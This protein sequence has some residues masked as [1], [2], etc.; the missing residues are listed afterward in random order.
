MKTKKIILVMFM[1]MT[2]LM[3]HACDTETDAEKSPDVQ[4]TA[5]TGADVS[6]EQDG[7]NHVV[8]SAVSFEHTLDDYVP[9]KK[10]YNFYFTYKIVQPW[11]DAV[12]MGLEDAA[13]QYAER[14]V[15]IN[16]EYLAPQA[17]DAEDQRKRLLD[18]GNRGFDV[19]GVDVADSAQITPVINLLINKGQ[20]VITFSSSDTDPKDGCKRI[21]Y[22][23]NTHNERDGAALAEALCER[24]GYAGKVGIIV[25]DHGAPCHEER[26][27]GARSVLD[28][29]PD[30]SI[31]GIDYDRESA[32]RAEKIASRFIDANPDIVGFIC[33]NMVNPVGVAH[34][35]AA[36][37]LEDQVT[38]VG[39]DH[40]ERA[41]RLLKDGS[42]Y[43][44][45]VQDCCSIGFDTI[46]TAI[47]VADGL[48]PGEG[49]EELTDE[50]TT[51]I[52]QKDAA[53]MLYKLY[54]DQE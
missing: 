37:K 47:K 15:T 26:L 21:A 39:M 43:C 23:G 14:G 38:I 12:A 11:W 19:I 49:Y 3:M 10:E 34:A 41:L 7:E 20:K 44:L 27:R 25:G 31:V 54:G 53:A 28:K 17:V 2:A 32:D 29:Y 36:K 48:K 16:Y 52:F 6:E 50:K 45:G 46:Q 1:C 9:K 40:D 51:L 42:I 18:A 4:E 5:E 30:I 33:C 22:V 13:D 8:E 24:I 35:V